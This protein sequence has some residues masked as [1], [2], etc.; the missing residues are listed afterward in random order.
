MIVKQDLWNLVDL[1]AIYVVTTN[2]YIKNNGSLVMGRG[3]ASQAVN[4]IPG[5]A[6]DCG[7][8]IANVGD[9]YS[10]LVIHHPTQIKAGFGIFQVKRFWGSDAELSLIEQSANRLSEFARKYPNLTIRMNYPGIGNGGLSRE[11]VE[12]L[13]KELAKVVTICYN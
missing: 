1:P 8:A 9:P 3:A 13:I 10:F 4:K 5:I 6:F 12:P 7:K 2:S 11:D